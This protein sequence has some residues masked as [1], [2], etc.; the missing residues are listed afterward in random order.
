MCA[1]PL[2]GTQSLVGQ[3]GWVFA[4]PSLTAI[5]V[6]WRWIFG[7]PLLAVCWM[8]AQRILTC[9]RSIPPA[10]TRSIRR[11][12]GSRRCR[13]TDAWAH[14]QPHVMAV[15]HWLL[16]LA[17]LAW[18]VVSGLG[19]NLVLKRLDPK[20]DLAVSL[21]AFADDRFAGRMACGAWLNLLGM[22]PLHPV[23]CGHAHHCSRASRTWSATPSG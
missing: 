22:V 5:E 8:Q 13:L 10:S 9:C 7:M 6:A 15:L 2:R 1:A 16:P 18:V 4:R 17:A 19:R 21:P 23:G 14:Y 12:P 20:S 3:M 11:I